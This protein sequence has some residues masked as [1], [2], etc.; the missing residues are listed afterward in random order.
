[1][2]ALTWSAY[3]V[4]ACL[5][6]ALVVGMVWAVRVYRDV[7]GEDDDPA[8]T[9]QGLLDPLEQ[10]FAAGQMSAEEYQKIR[11]SVVRVAGR[12]DLLP[13]LR[14]RNRSTPRPVLPPVDDPES[15]DAGAD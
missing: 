5:T 9:P 12:G 6:V 11:S 10:A 4:L 14:D 13:E 8:D 15:D 3:L 1:M 2:P 7:R